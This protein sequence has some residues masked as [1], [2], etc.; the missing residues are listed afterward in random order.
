M[1]LITNKE[2]LVKLANAKNASKISLLQ[3]DL[4]QALYNERKAI[5]DMY[6]DTDIPLMKTEMQIVFDKYN[7]M[8]VVLKEASTEING[9]QVRLSDLEPLVYDALNKG[10]DNPLKITRDLGVILI[11][12]TTS[13]GIE[14]D[15]DE[16]SQDRMARAII[17][18]DDV[19]TIA[20]IDASG[21]IQQ[22]TKAILQEALKSAG[23]AQTQLFAEYSSQK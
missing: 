22:L 7:A 16:L 11:K 18:M 15:G 6:V 8:D 5:Y 4:K 17:C 20:W 9:R 14:L 13:G 19:E 1:E 3:D 12:I 10:V 2:L 23:I 21:N